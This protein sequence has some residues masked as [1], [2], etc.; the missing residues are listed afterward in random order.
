MFTIENLQFFMELVG[1]FAFA[2]SGALMAIRKHFDVFGVCVLGVTASVGGGLIRDLI[3]GNK[4]PAMFKDPTYTEIAVGVSLILFIL[5]YKKHDPTAGEHTKAY[6]LI[7]NIFDTIGLGIFTVAGMDTARGCG[8]RAGFIV[9][10]VGVLTGVG[11]GVLR[12]VLAQEKPYILTRHI[13]ACASIVGAIVC[14]YTY[15]PFGEA[16]SM[17]AGAFTVMLIRGLAIRYNWNLPKI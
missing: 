9:I 8:Y 12:D 11:G 13:Y 17:F 7:I 5:I 14:F 16:I 2:S 3:L 1:T 10:F 6:D 15:Y 4:P